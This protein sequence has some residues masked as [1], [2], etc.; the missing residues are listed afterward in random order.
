[1]A[2]LKS[3][4]NQRKSLILLWRHERPLHHPSIRSRSLLGTHLVHRSICLSTPYPI[5]H[6]QEK[7][8]A[9]LSFRSVLLH[10]Y[11][12]TGV[13]LDTTAQ[14]L[15]VC[16]VLSSYPWCVFHLNCT[17]TPVITLS[18]GS[19]A[20]A[21]ITWRNS[22]VFHDYDKV[23]SLFIHM[24]PTLTFSV[25]RSVFLASYLFVYPSLTFLKKK[26]DTFIPTHTSVSPPSLNS[27]TSNLYERSSSPP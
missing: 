1:M 8:L 7:T 19:L 14:R 24:Y 2:L 4:P 17:L 27:L 16:G 12:G 26:K 13:Y 22:L 5:L 6:V 20:S 23:T 3:Y 11:L 25:I 10:Q 15:V 18:L 9:L 21:I